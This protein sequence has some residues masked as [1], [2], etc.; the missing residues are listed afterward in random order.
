[1]K[2]VLFAYAA[3]FPSGTEYTGGVMGSLAW[4][5]EVDAPWPA[6]GV[7]RSF[8]VER[9]TAPGVGASRTFTIRKNGADTALTVTLS[10]LATSARL[11]GVDVSVAAGDLVAVKATATG[12]PDAGNGTRWS[13]EF[14]GTMPN[15]SAYAQQLSTTGTT[16]VARQT[17]VF[18]FPSTY[19][20]TVRNVVAAAGTLTGMRARVNT[21]PGVGNGMTFYLN[22]NG[23]RQDGSGGTVNTACALVGAITTASASYSLPL[24]AGDVVYTEAVPSGSFTTRFFGLGVSFIATTDGESQCCGGE[25]LPATTQYGQVPINLS[26]LPS[27]TETAF[28]SRFAGGVSSIVLSGMQLLFTVAPG[29]GKSRTLDLRRNAASVGPTVTIS[30]AA[31]TGSDLVN[32]ATIADGDFWNLR[33][34]PTNTPAATTA[35]W[36]FIQRT[37]SAAVERSTP[38]VGPL[39]VS[40]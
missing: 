13:L 4:G 33:F 14:E 7:F 11:T 20:A 34:V 31:T 17:G 40:G 36:S 9:I 15:E 25:D 26:A 10:D 32:M 21:A 37:V 27:T 5:S 35:F 18:A 19:I 2:Q 38:F 12:A 8:L 24:V 29:A 3:S 39:I 28:A 16:A 30:D 1:M 23:T 22:K 6:P